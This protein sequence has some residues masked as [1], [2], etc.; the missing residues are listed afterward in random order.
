MIIL[1]CGVFDLFHIGHLIYFQKIKN[2]DDTLIVL[3]NSDKFA[4]SYKRTP[5]INEN[6]RFEIINSLKIVDFAFIDDNDHLTE[7]IMKKYNIDIVIQAS[8]E[9]AWNYYYNLPIKQN[10][11]KFIQYNDNNNST[12]KII[13]KILDINKES[14][15]FTNRYTEVEILKSEKLYGYG[16]QS[17][18]GFKFLNDIINNI[19]FL[20]K[21]Q[22][23]L[24]I[25]CGLGGN[26][27]EL[28]KK[29][30]CNVTGIDI[31]APMINICKERNT[32]VDIKYEIDDY[33]NYNT[34][35]QFDLILC[36][37]VFLYIENNNKLNY[38]KKCKSE[39]NK[40]GIF[41]LIDYCIGK[42]DSCNF[43][44]YRKRRNWNCI[45]I[46]DYEKNLK[47]AGF[48]ILES[49]NISEKYINNAIKI[50][51]TNTEIEQDVL[52]NL[53]SKINFLRNEWFEWHYFVLK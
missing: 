18:G 46:P 37:D 50:K 8:G 36:R 22:K 17:L 30:N 21:P 26:C 53:D 43:Q 28:Q 44:K 3:V 39:L 42:Y 35:I 49:V 19:I 47:E 25:G 29:L 2:K 7:E 15:D 24:E 16:Y 38:L 33:I 11:M 34:N 9:N 31:C 4:N 12:T 41:I 6:E 13:N 27:I 52:D 45:S 10:K 40:E 20:N 48:D 14:D 51:D 1:T 23:I 32:N 5:I